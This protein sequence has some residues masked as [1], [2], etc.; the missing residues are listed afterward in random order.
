MRLGVITKYKIGYDGYGIQVLNIFP[1][2][3]TYNHITHRYKYYPTRYYIKY[4]NRLWL[5]EGYKMDTL[6]NKL[7]LDQMKANKQTSGYLLTYKA[8]MTDRLWTFADLHKIKLVDTISVYSNTD[9]HSE[10]DKILKDRKNWPYDNE[11][12]YIDYKFIKSEGCPI[13]LQKIRKARGWQIEISKN[14]VILQKSLLD[15]TGEKQIEVY[16]CYTTLNYLK[17]LQ[18]KYVTK[19]WVFSI[20]NSPNKYFK[21]SRVESFNRLIQKGK[22]VV[23]DK[24]LAQQ[25]LKIRSTKGYTVEYIYDQTKVPLNKCKSVTIPRSSRKHKIVSCR[26]TQED[27]DNQRLV[28]ITDGI[29]VNRLKKYKA[30][31]LIAQFPTMKFCKKS[32]Y[33]HYLNELRWKDTKVSVQ[34]DPKNPSDKRTR[35]E[36]RFVKQKNKSYSRGKFKQYIKGEKWV[37]DETGEYETLVEVRPKTINVKRSKPSY[38]PRKVHNKRFYYDR[39]FNEYVKVFGSFDRRGNAFNGSEKWS[40]QFIILLSMIKTGKRECDIAK[41]ISDIFPGW[42]DKKIKRFII[43]LKLTKNGLNKNRIIPTVQKYRWETHTIQ[44]IKINQFPYDKHIAIDYETPSEEGGVKFVVEQDVSIRGK[45]IVKVDTDINEIRVICS[46]KDV[47]KWVL[48]ENYVDGSECRWTNLI[49]IVPYEKE[50]AIKIPFK[51]K[52]KTIKKKK[53]ICPMKVEKV[54]F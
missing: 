8:D 32:E 26:V 43:Y 35:K 18:N 7:M 1:E 51:L 10:I 54:P 12:G 2:G 3:V 38:M 45:K 30:D 24:H 4:N 15:S 14:K 6:I 53:W 22:V 5:V 31:K 42:N 13:K 25:C 19:A 49:D 44:G 11:I 36:R 48:Q 9:D 29:T 17:Y 46:I 16:S 23:T 40:N 21:L 37:L 39:L 47:R 34:G 41:Y 52:Q 27:I 20:I 33:H 50:V 28:C